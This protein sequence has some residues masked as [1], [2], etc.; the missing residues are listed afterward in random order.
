MYDAP[1]RPALR[2]LVPRLAAL[3]VAS[4]VVLRLAAG[5]DVRAATVIT[6]AALGVMIAVRVVWRGPQV[7][8]FA[9]DDAL[10]VKGPEGDRSIPWTVV[11]RVR[12]TAGEVTTARGVV[13]VCYAHVDVAHGPPVAFADLS[14]MGSPRLR[15]VEGDA[16]V[17]DVGDPE[18]LL[19]AIA[20]RVDATEFLPPTDRTPDGETVGPWITASP[21]AVLRLG[22]AV[23]VGH[24]VLAQLHTADAVMA[25]CAGAMAVVAPHA[26]VR[27]VIQRNLRGS[28][29]EVGAP[30]AVAVGA[31]VALVLAFPL[32]AMVPVTV[33]AWSV[34]V[35]LLCALPAWPMPGAY[36]VRRLGRALA[37][38]PDAVGAAAVVALAVVSAWC[39]AKG[40]VLLPIALLAGGLEGAEGV[41]ATR[42]HRALSVLPRFRRWPPL[43]LAR[44]RSAMRP[45][46]VDRVDAR[47]A[48]VDV[49]E[50]RDAALTPPPPQWLP[51]VVCALGVGVLALAARMLAALPASEALA[52][53]WVLT[54]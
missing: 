41:A 21:L 54:S 16:P 44:M 15:T 8:V 28:Q 20:E 5:L 33:G 19:G 7:R 11:E 27:F 37:D 23:M 24:R 13:R 43:A 49:V 35:A 26:L 10:V 12:L 48:S 34:V 42:R 2:D 46:D 4:W 32:R 1:F 50:L 3:A 30:P 9:T 36:V 22:L 29:S 38:W 18:L 31:L 51:L 53:L 47:L 25:F 52:P 17:H 14:P 40:L 39:F 6:V 45:T